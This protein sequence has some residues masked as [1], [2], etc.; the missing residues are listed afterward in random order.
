MDIERSLLLKTCVDR[1]Q[2]LEKVLEAISSEETFK[3]AA[4]SEQYCKEGN[5]LYSQK[6]HNTET[7]Q[8]IFSRYSKSI[9]W[10]PLNSQELA[11]AYENRSRFLLHMDKYKDCI[12][13]INKALE[14]TTS[15]I[16][17]TELVCRKAECLKKLSSLEYQVEACP[18]TNSMSYEEPENTLL[19]VDESPYCISIDY[20]EK[21]GR[22]LNA[23]KDYKP[24]ELIFSEQLYASVLNPIMYHTNCNYCLKVCWSGIPCNYCNWAMFCSEDCR[25]KGWEAF[26][27][28]ECSVIPYLQEI[29]SNFFDSMSMSLRILLVGIREAG[30]IVQ[31]MDNLQVAEKC[32]GN[33]VNL[34]KFNARLKF[35]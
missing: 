27:A 12:K 1:R 18:K 15:D 35:F 5:A 19:Q 11:L 32:T 4:Y 26:H 10:A 9:C 31:L 16:K 14:L 22:H 21:Y 6:N 23:T 3:D 29:F 7:H 13:D 8:E 25:Q 34:I 2:H 28:I 30:S 33:T 20:N 24:G 17:K